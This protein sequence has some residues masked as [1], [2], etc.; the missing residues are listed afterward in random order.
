MRLFSLYAHQE[1]DDDDRSRSQSKRLTRNS[2]GRSVN[3][4]LP[5]SEKKKPAKR[6]RDSDRAAEP[7]QQESDR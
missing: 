3:F 2:M 4:D 5:S 1:E 7:P 6:S